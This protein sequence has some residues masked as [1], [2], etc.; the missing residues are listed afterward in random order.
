MA[1]QGTLTV[2]NQ[3]R[4]DLGLTVR[5]AEP[6]PLPVPG[7]AGAE[8]ISVSGQTVLV[9]I[10]DPLNPTRRGKPLGVAGATIVSY[11]GDEPSL[12][13]AEWTF[14]GN[15]TRTKVQVA[16]PS[17]L[18]AGTKVWIAAFFFN[19]RGQSGQACDPVGTNLQGGSL[20][21]A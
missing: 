11:V 1:I 20:M 21:A 17:T 19:P 16:F 2:T 18:T 4:T 7:K 14:Q 5:D 3:Q 13:P 6:T 15:T 12:N 8:V 10:Y 9:R